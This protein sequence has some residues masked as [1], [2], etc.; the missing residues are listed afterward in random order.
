MEQYSIIAGLEN[1]WDIQYGFLGQLRQGIYSEESFE[2]LIKLIKELD[3]PNENVVNR[4][5]VSLLW[6]IPIVMNWQKERFIKNN[7]PFDKLEKSINQIINLLENYLG[8]P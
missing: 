2:R 8:I 6:Y 4:R 3:T 5:L 7:I 1:E